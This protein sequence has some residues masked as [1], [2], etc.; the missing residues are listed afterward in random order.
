MAKASFFCVCETRVAAT[1]RS[2]AEYLH[3]SITTT[4]GFTMMVLVFTVASRQ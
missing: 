3:K 2:W 4:L 1:R